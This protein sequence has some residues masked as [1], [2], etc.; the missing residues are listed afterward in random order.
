MQVASDGCSAVGDALD[1][2]LVP[3]LH[4]DAVLDSA[5]GCAILRCAWEVLCAAERMQVS[6]AV[7][8]SRGQ[9]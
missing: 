8:R 4:G 9:G 5:Q 7:L 6:C 2:G 1:A 3:V